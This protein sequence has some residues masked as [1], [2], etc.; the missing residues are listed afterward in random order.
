MLT[1]GFKL[2]TGFGL[3]ALISALAYGIVSGNTSGPDYLQVIDRSAFKG[4]VSFGW[5][6]GIGEHLGYV[7]FFFVFL[8][9][10]F[11]ALMLTAFSDADPSAVA[12]IS[13][14]GE[15]PPAQAA[16]A[17]SY[18]PV[19]L[20]F[21]VGL[22]VVGL[23]TNPAIM[24]IGIVFAGVAGLEW[25]ISAWAERAS[26]DPEVNKAVRNRLLWPI[27]VPAVGAAGIAVL[28]LGVW[29]VLI[30]VSEFSAVWVVTGL[31]AAVFVIAVAFAYAPKISKSAVVGVVALAAVGAI[32]AGIVATAIGSREFHDLHEELL[33]SQA[34]VV[35]ADGESEAAA[36]GLA[37]TSGAGT[38]ADHG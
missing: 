38:E 3:A 14:E 21:G 15:V 16:T 1:R 5:Q 31:S 18:W 34:E 32:V 17:P 30:A 26:S 2:Y 28:V 6:G 8:V 25:A 4:V 35:G 19:V 22:A 12:E 13:D 27:E 20:A 11:L 36:S 10:L 33:H 24:V 37:S 23:A 29:R 9:S 7:V